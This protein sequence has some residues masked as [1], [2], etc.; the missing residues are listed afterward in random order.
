MISATPRWKIA[1]E[2]AIEGDG[3]ANV[4]QL[5]S[6]DASNSDIPHVRSLILR[7]FLSSKALPALPLLITTTDV[8]TPKTIQI[9]RNSNIE[10]VFWV[11]NTLEQYRLSGHASIIPEPSHPYYIHFASSN[12]P[13]L[14]ALKKEDIDWEAKRVE[15]F[16][17]L[18]G[19]MKASWC[20]PVPGSK[21]EGGYEEAEKW[22]K[23]L[24]KLGEEQN[25]ADRQNLQI[26]LGNFALVV[27]DPVAV[28]FVELGVFPNRRTNFLRH[29]ETWEEEILVP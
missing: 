4:F 19:R 1:L 16:D 2:K 22:P 23:E 7:Q 26:A 17:S 20:R 15:I 5:A 24:P 9:R 29:G 18:S 14:N 13:T 28:D 27:I 11:E 8:R 21:L 3:K 6:I 25:E 12:W 10:A